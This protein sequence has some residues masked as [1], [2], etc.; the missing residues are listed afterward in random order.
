MIQNLWSR[1][2]GP[3]LTLVLALVVTTGLILVNIELSIALFWGW[4]VGSAVCFCLAFWRRHA[5]WAASGF[6]LLGGALVAALI[7]QGI[8]DWWWPLALTALGVIYLSL[9]SMLPD[10]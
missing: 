10:H 8:A 3:T 2:V 1:I 5:A 9:A 7:W 6:I 4:L